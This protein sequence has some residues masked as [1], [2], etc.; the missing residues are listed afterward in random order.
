MSLNRSLIYNEIPANVGLFLIVVNPTLQVF[1]L[2]REVVGQD[3]HAGLLP[4]IALALI[5]MS[6]LLKKRVSVGSINFI[7]VG[8]VLFLGIIGMMHSWLSSS[9]G[10]IRTMYFIIAFLITPLTAAMTLGPRRS[11]E[12]L[13]VSVV[14]CSAFLCIGSQLIPSLFYTQT[15]VSYTPYSLGWFANPNMYGVTAFIGLAALVYIR[16]I[17]LRKKN[18]MHRILY[19]ILYLSYILAIV[20]S[21]SRASGLSLLVFFLI[22]IIARLRI[23]VKQFIKSHVIFVV[24]LIVI[25]GFV[26][27]SFGW[28]SVFDWV[29]DFVYKHEGEISGG[30]L[31]LWRHLLSYWWS[32]SPLFGLGI[33]AA[34]NEAQKIGFS[35]SHSAYVRLIIEHGVVGVFILFGIIR[36]SFST[37]KLEEES[38][39]LIFAILVSILTH[40][41]FE[42]HIMSLGITLSSVIFAQL[43][44]I[45]ATRKGKGIPSRSYFLSQRD[46]IL[47][48]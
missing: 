14:I 46:S 13:L 10:I 45:G 39:L 36:S 25:V 33:G 4:L 3:I 8:L 47:V 9:E 12:I 40:S 44:V 27:G 11:L 38:D 19:G 6:L 18:I 16:H 26:A 17:D 15:R 7:N 23:I 32:E 31:S 30:R 43:I 29:A 35:G 28:R 24:L 37:L 5:I 22:I 48:Q 42:D 1:S 41:L 34:S 21:K 20:L 2:T